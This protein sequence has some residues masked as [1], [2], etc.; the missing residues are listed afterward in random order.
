MGKKVFEMSKFF[1]ELEILI[2]NID[3][4]QEILDD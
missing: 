3:I 1:E 2:H 4:P